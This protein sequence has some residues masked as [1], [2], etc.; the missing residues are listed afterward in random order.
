MGI[1]NKTKEVQTGIKKTLESIRKQFGDESVMLLGEGGRKEIPCVSS[2]SLSIDIALK[3]GGYPRG[4]LVE[5]YGPE[6]SGKTTLTLHAVAQMQKEGGMCAFI[7]AEHALDTDYA[8]KLGV[9]T[10][11]LLLS[12]PDHGEQALAITHALIQSGDID[13]IVVD[14]VAALVPKA[15]LEGNVGDHHVGSQ[16]RMMSQA[17]RMLTGAANKFGTT[18]IFINQIRQKIGVMFGSPETTTGG[19]AL[20]FYTSVRLDVRRIGQIKVS[21]SEDPIG[22]RTK[23]K[24]IKNKLAPPFRLAEF[25]II[26]GDGVSRNHEI[27]EIGEKLNILTKSGTWYSYNDIRLGQGKDKA[28]AYLK[29]NSKL[30]SEIEKMILNHCQ[31]SNDISE[32]KEDPQEN[33][34]TPQKEVA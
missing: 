17:M 34:E 30:A 4:R 22:A 14:S 11:N 5:I 8:R 13:L 29:E 7:D 12:Q 15:E 20:K 18:V 25:D 32:N 3:I 26:Y 16:A 21:T 2:G 33:K 10:D 31:S 24:V 28:V 6:S 19:N 23:V 27:I 1:K 9:D